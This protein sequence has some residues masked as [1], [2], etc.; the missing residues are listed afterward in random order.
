MPKPVLLIW[1]M[2]PEALKIFHFTDLSE[3]EFE[4]LLKC[5]GEMEGASDNSNEVDE[6]LGWLG[7]FLQDVD[8]IYDSDN[9]DLK[10]PPAIGAD[11]YEGVV[12]VH[13]GFLM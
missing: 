11:H 6:A 7:P 1:E 9:E 5:H 8:P 10:V 12:I 13:T 2:V 3:V 4:N